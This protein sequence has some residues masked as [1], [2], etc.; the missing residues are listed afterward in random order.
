[1]IKV[2]I[3]KN[4]AL[5]V[6]HRF[7]E[8]FEDDVQEAIEDTVA[9]VENIALETVTDCYNL[10]RLNAWM[11]YN[12]EDTIGNLS[13][14]VTIKSEFIPL[15]GNFP[16]DI[17]EGRIS[18]APKLKAQTRR[19]DKVTVDYKTG[20]TISFASY[21][22]IG[23]GTAYT[24]TQTDSYPIYA[25]YSPSIPVMLRDEIDYFSQLI[26]EAFEENIQEALGDL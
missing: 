21:N 4:K 17:Q 20:R 5:N 15:V 3:D 23:A 2:T 9:E 7:A 19:G 16:F 25:F 14:E 12:A 11:Y 26:E 13:A 1:M 24:R 10:N 22:L 8:E 18:I 6:L